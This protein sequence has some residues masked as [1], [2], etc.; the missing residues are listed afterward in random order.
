MTCTSLSIFITDIFEGDK[1]NEI[2]ISEIFPIIQNNEYTNPRL[3]ELRDIGQLFEKIANNPYDVIS[4]NNKTLDK[5]TIWSADS[6]PGKGYVL[7][8]KIPHIG[9]T[10]LTTIHYI[11]ARERGHLIVW[12]GNSEYKENGASKFPFLFFQKK[13]NNF[14]LIAKTVE[15][16]GTIYE[17]MPNYI[18]LDIDLDHYIFS[19]YDELKY[20]E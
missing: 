19:V 18:N 16:L 15:Y 14:E 5:I 3:T 11:H 8:S 1:Y 17:I 2:C 10:N 6:I 7:T 9:L 12:N 13:D 20:K 4:S